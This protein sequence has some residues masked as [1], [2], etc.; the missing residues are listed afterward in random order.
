MDTVVSL[1]VAAEELLVCQD[2]FDDGAGLLIVEYD[3]VVGYTDFRH[4]WSVAGKDLGSFNH[5]H[6]DV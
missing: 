6:E 1:A 4:E 3:A 2:D 5:I